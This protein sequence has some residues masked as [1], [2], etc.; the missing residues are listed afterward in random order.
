MTVFSQMTSLASAVIHATGLT[1]INSAP[2]VTLKFKSEADAVR[3]ERV[4]MHDINR[5]LD[6]SM[7][8]QRDEN[9]LTIRGISFKIAHPDRM[10]YTPGVP[11]K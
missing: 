5:L 3:F 8:T 9:R 10:P 1:D 2:E 6:R 4:L 11:S 7:A